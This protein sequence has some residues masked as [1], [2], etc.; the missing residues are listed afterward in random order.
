V[1]TTV[2][3]VIAVLNASADVVQMLREALEEEG[4]VVAT[5]TLPE[6][7]RG[8]QDV[9]EFFQQHDP[10]AVVYD[11]SPPYG[12]NWTFLKLIR[13]T[14]AAKNRTFILTTTNKH[15][16][17]EEVGPTDAREVIGKPYDLGQ[18]VKAVQAALKS[19]R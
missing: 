19:R 13:D 8:R 10:A 14:E 11:I 17:E 18:V 16:L 4:Y 3:Q 6:I 7:K 5:A 15:A 12:E 9:V 2:R 1:A